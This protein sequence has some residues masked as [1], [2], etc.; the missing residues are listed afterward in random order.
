MRM[1]LLANP[2]SGSGEAVEAEQAL[3]A[4]VSELARFALD[5]RAAVAD[6]RP[7]RIVVAGGDGSIGRAAEV[8]AE[9][10]VP[11]A[12]IPVGTANDFARALGI[13]RDLEAAIEFALKSSR[14]TSLDLAYATDLDDGDGIGRPFVNAASAGLS[15]AA[16]RR[17]GTLKRPLGPLAYAVGALRAGLTAQP[18]A[19]RVAVDDAEVFSGEAWQVTVA[20]TGAFGGG[21]EINADPGDGLL[22]A[23]VIEAGSRVR[24][25]AHAYGLRAGEIEER[26]DV[27]T[28]TGHAIDVEADGDGFNVDGELLEARAL[29]CTV[30][31]RA[32]EVVVG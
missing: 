14:T 12:V 3:S 25:L 5:Q 7:E 20:C 1:A 10:G 24:L 30:R 32:F 2:E 11:L 13:P 22:D 15:P 31:F 8:A 23:V 6:W 29:R 27:R 18:V 4:Q 28:A 26:A 16:A 21:A 9:L 17:A 19:S